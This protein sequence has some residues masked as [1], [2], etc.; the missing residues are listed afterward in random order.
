MLF[1]TVPITN[2]TGMGI[3]SDVQHK[4]MSIHLKQHRLLTNQ[5]VHLHISLFVSLLIGEKTSDANELRLMPK[6]DFEDSGFICL[7]MMRS[8]ERGIVLCYSTHMVIV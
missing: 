5:H 4:L 6:P 1:F 7:P 2:I 3:I 8:E